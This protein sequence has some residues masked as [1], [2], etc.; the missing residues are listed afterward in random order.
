[1]NRSTDQKINEVESKLEQMHEQT[2]D[3]LRMAMEKIEQALQNCQGQLDILHARFAGIEE[4]SSS[5][6]GKVLSFLG[7]L[8]AC[9]RN[10]SALEKKMNLHID[11]SEAQIGEIKSQFV[12]FKTSIAEDWD[13]RQQSH[14]NILAQVETLL[15]EQPTAH[16]SDEKYELIF[17]RLEK[18]EENNDQIL[19]TLSEPLRTDS[20]GSQS[21]KVIEKIIGKIGHLEK[22]IEVIRSECRLNGLRSETALKSKIVKLRKMMRLVSVPGVHSKSVCK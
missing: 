18:I 6:G 22:D 11:L 14:H 12:T 4:L 15:N 1:M 19:R 2:R 3:D 17:D 20:R 9:S 7:E 16:L 5:S 10:L 13:Q 8:E 21:S